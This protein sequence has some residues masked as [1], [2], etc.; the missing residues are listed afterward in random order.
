M[1]PYSTQ[2]IDKKDIEEV[3]KTLKSPFLTQGPKGIAFRN[4]YIGSFF[5]IALTTL[6]ILNLMSMN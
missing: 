4:K 5:W 1:I 2:K 3:L 6:I